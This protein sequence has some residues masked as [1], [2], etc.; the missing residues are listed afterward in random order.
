MEPELEDLMALFDTSWL[1]MQKLCFGFFFFLNSLNNDVKSARRIL[2]VL[3][4]T[5]KDNR[6][7]GQ[8]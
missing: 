4:N 3:Q 7:R 1:A 5:G 8:L 2:V 6:K